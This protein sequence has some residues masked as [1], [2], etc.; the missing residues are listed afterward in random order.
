M[1]VFYYH[2]NQ[3]EFNLKALPEA[4]SANTLD[5]SSIQLPAGVYTTIRTYH[6]AQALYFD[7]HIDRLERS[8]YLT[9]N[10][11][12]INRPQLRQAIF[13]AMQIVGQRDQR[14]RITVIPQKDSSFGIYLAFS[15]LVVPSK[16]AYEQGVRAVTAMMKR[17]NS[18]AKVTD[19]I[20]S[21]HATRQSLPEGTNELFM[22]ENGGVFLEGLTSNIFCVEN[23]TIW[24]A[25]KDVLP[26][27]TRQVVI[28]LIQAQRIPLVLSG[29]P[30]EKMGHLDEVFITS[31]SRAVLPVTRINKISIGSGKPGAITKLLANAYKA[32]IEASIK[33]I[34][35]AAVSSPSS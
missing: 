2:S 27:I 17:E 22:I 23:G 8:A 29:Y 25:D 3:K 19:F 31:T 32:H 1:Q 33:P 26:G 10:F 18:E 34:Y 13:Q 11:I 28:E 30:Y 5:E 20:K 7:R 16:R 35:D 4:S 12:R 24:T 14:I 15:D 21:T 9:G 6:Q